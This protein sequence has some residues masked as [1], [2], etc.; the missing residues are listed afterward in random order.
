MASDSGEVPEDD[1]ARMKSWIVLCLPDVRL[2][3]LSPITAIRDPSSK[4]DHEHHQW[5]R[6]LKSNRFRLKRSSLALMSYINLLQT[7][8]QLSSGHLLPHST[9]ISI[10]S[11]FSNVASGFQTSGISVSSR[12]DAK[13]TLIV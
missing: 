6:I 12:Q 8:S 3:G 5:I 13:C 10:P 2:A 7:K 9:L 11:A 1:E 4:R